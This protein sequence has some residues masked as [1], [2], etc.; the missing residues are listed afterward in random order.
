LV[1]CRD[2]IGDTSIAGDMRWGGSFGVNIDFVARS[3]CSVEFILMEDMEVSLY[4]Q[5][6]TTKN[7]F[8]VNVR[9]ILSILIS[10]TEKL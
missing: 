3:H 4:L 7:M 10:I 8:L 6:G 9:G 1:F 5:V 2:S